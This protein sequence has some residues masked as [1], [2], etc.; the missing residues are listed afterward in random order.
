ML[1]LIIPAG[2]A[3]L[4]IV[5]VGLPLLIIT[6]RNCCRKRRESLS[7]DG[8]LSIGFFHPYCNAGGGGERVLWCAVKAVQS[9]YA[10]VKIVIY[11]GDLDASPEEILKRAEQ[12]FNIKLTDPVQF[13]YLRRRR[14]VEAEMYPYFTLLGQSLG[15][16]VLGAEALAA[17]VPALWLGWSVLR[18]CDGQ[19]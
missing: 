1:K 13:V 10:H 19:F 18:H 17:F 15:S 14:W 9:R 11:T 16:I 6:S 4:L 5:I 8:I 3:L 7:K 12:R 2:I